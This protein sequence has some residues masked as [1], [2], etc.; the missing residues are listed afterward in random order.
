MGFKKFSFTQ[1][2]DGEKHFVKCLTC[3]APRIAYE[4][5]G[6]FS[7][8]ILRSFIS[9][10]SDSGMDYRIECNKCHEHEEAF[11]YGVFMATDNG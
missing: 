6:F 8:Y 3:S 1:S 4:D 7:V 10:L 11:V 9:K 5:E 2:D